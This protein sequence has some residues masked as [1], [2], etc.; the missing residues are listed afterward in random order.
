MHGDS[1]QAAV[2]NSKNVLDDDDDDEPEA[3]PPLHQRNHLGKPLDGQRERG[4]SEKG[5]STAESELADHGRQHARQNHGREIRKEQPSQRV[6]NSKQQSAGTVPAES[7]SKSD[8]S[9]LESSEHNKDRPKMNE[10]RSARVD[11]LK[12]WYH[13]KHGSS[14]SKRGQASA[15]TE[16]RK[17]HSMPNIG[18]SQSDEKAGKE[19]K[20]HDE[21]DWGFWQTEHYG[22]IFRVVDGE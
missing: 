11:E 5:Q 7:S 15:I 2:R 18:V 21:S 3:E 12:R 4:K 6:Q 16:K 14:Q 19:G 8:E 9:D 13:E 20:Q 22:S 17:G 1:R 10:E